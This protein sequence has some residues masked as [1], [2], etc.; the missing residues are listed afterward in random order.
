M[1][2][3]ERGAAPVVGVVLVVAIV[4]ILAAT[5][6]VFTFGFAENLTEPGPNVAESTGELIQQSGFDGGIIRITHEAGDAVAVED[7]EIAVD[8]TDSCGERERLINLPEDDSNNAGRFADTN[9][10]SGSISGSIIDGGFI[11]DLGVVDSRTTNRF[12][13]GT[14]LQFRLTGGDCPL[15]NRDEVIVRVV[16][17]PSNSVIITQRLIV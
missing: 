14:F 10:R 7:I 8:A 9:V 5:V 17:V 16:H 13:S 6:S 2:T 11:T 4:I 12:T 3:N 15:D 1:G